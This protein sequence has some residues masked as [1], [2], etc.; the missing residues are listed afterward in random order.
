[1]SKCN[2]DGR[3]KEIGELIAYNKNLKAL[4]LQKVNMNDTYASVL[5]QPLADAFHLE[6][7]KLDFN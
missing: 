3:F 6:N 7:L 4:T 1:M 5:V 2:F